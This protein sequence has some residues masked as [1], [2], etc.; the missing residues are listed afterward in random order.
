MKKRKKQK[1]PVDI[2][3][4]ILSYGI[5]LFLTIKAGINVFSSNKQNIE[6]IFNTTLKIFFI[7]GSLIIMLIL[8]I[9]AIKHLKEKE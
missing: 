8:I 4:T 2:L 3:I 1:N 7:V 5:A 6:Y 9:K